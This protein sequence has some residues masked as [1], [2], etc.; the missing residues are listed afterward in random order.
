MV[1]EKKDA[2]RNADLKPDSVISQQCGISNVVKV[3]ASLF[4]CL[5]VCVCVTIIAR[6]CEMFEKSNYELLYFSRLTRLRMRLQ[7]AT[8]D[9]FECDQFSS[10]TLLFF[11]GIKLWF[12]GTST[13]TDTLRVG[14][15]SSFGP[16]GSLGITLFV[17]IPGS[18]FRTH[19]EPCPSLSS[20]GCT[21]FQ[22]KRL[23]IIFAAPN[24]WS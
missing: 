14:T 13:K 17:V 15:Q 23:T 9:A 11:D 12:L 16:L 18:S 6:K 22:W 1:A 5:W 4:G 7:P 8:H 19:L 3:F 2:T 10:I 24:K 21:N 20:F